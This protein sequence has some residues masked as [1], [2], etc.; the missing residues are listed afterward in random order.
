MKQ[1]TLFFVFIFISIFTFNSKGE[2]NKPI[3]PLEYTSQGK[4]EY[5]SEFTQTIP[6]EDNWWKIFNDNCLD[7]LI[8][9]AIKNNT[10]LS[11]AAK[12]ISI[13]K[14]SIKLAQS[15][16]YPSMSLSAGW[17]R[18]RDTGHASNSTSLGMD[19]NWEIDVF[20]K[21]T[22]QANVKKALWKA[23][24]SDYDAMMIS[25][26]ANVATSYINLRTL[27]AQYIVATT[28]IQSQTLV[29]DLTEARYKSGL[30]SMLD[31]LQAKTLYLSTLSTLSPLQSN[32]E[33]Q[34][35]NIALLVGV[36]KNMLPESATQSISLPNVEQIIPAGIPMDIIRRR[37]DIKEAEYTLASYAEEIGVAKKD[38]LPTLSLEGEI[39][40]KSN[41]IDELFNNDSFSY[42]I[43][44]TLTWTIFNGLERKYQ[45]I[46]AK[47]QYMIG[48][49]N[50]NYAVST[51]INEVDNALITYKYILQDTNE[52][53]HVTEVAFNS[54]KISID[55][56][57]RG[58]SNFTNVLTSQ[59]SYLQYNNEYI[60]SK[61]KSLLA[62]IS[63]YQALGGGW[64]Y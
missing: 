16:Y 53:N 39:G 4:W 59:Q 52:L 33:T 7:S 19:F 24:K 11:I 9:L 61:G 36:N 22:S 50:Y 63:I 60:T 56:Y 54:L 38:F 35:N 28:H 27:Q 1:R 2:D 3:E 45:L 46:E 42:T 13:A 31:V 18:S 30:V 25:L 55:L 20:G 51:A 23:S 32:I 58:L 26:C 17:N 43:A 44:P 49:D 62:L 8:E 15:G 10:D 12:K 57:K 5:T 41:K 21:I 47:E 29:L 6:T 14:S 40:F 48:I 64:S 34:I 37:P